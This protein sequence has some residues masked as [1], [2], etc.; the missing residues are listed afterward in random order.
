MSVLH[1]PKQPDVQLKLLWFPGL[2]AVMLFALATRLWYIQ[3][4]KA[5]DILEEATFSRAVGLSIPAP[6]GQIFDRSGRALTSTRTAMAV[7]IKPGVYKKNPQM[8]AK[9]AS[10]LGMEPEAVQDVVNEFG[11]R[12]NMPATLKVGVD[13]HTAARVLESKGISG[14][15]VEQIPVRGYVDTAHF[16]HL[17]GYVRPPSAEDVERLEQAKIPIG[18]MVGKVG[19]ERWAEKDLAGS[20]GSIV[21]ETKGKNK[22]EARTEPVAGKKVYLTID[23]ELQTYC[24]AVL[25]GRGFRGAIV[26]IDPSN[27][28]ILAM[29]SNPSYD[30]SLFVNGISKAQF[31]ALQNDTRKPQFNRPIA[32]ALKP[33]STFKILTSMAAY[34]AGKLKPGTA[35][36]CNGGYRAGKVGR[37]LKCM[38]THGAIGYT[39]AMT[40]SC[41]TYF[42]TIGVRSG[43]DTFVQTCTDLGFGKLTGVEIPGE[44]R[45]S[46]P[47]D[48]WVARMN[49]RR[50]EK[51]QIK[52]SNGDL[53]NMSL[54]QGYITATPLQMANLAAVVANEGIGY[55]PHLI[56]GVEGTVMGQVSQYKPEISVKFSADKWF[57]QNLKTGL[58][59][60]ID[61][62]TAKSAQIGGLAW[63][64]K[65]GSAEN[66]NKNQLTDAWFV[67]FAPR[68]NPK[69]AICVMAEKAGHG[70]DAS[71]P[72]ARE[73]VSHY[74]FRSAKPESKADSAPKK[75]TSGSRLA[76][77]NAS[78][79]S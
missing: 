64:G 11:F 76:A 9:L 41:N 50:S 47:T 69:I 2:V 71:A 3:V 65:T 77:R 21:V 34:R 10:I 35:V 54:G 78:R 27:G 67:G 1:A 48:E 72:L 63:S 57:W 5:D 42:A 55:R 56:R 37:M 58:A 68:R 18:D 24:Q 62:G 40:R 30:T 15:D 53:A 45:G 16:S 36:T 32:A 38:G 12:P 29:V 60:V 28:E 74:F 19:I 14:A 61:Y 39:G 44:Y 75:S 31:S 8:V 33:G 43:M 23:S 51:M 66:A 4:V 49:K 17:L 79:R 70:G 73:V 46:V 7:T 25:S 6:R 20:P 52:P 59:G 13:M 22:F 26:A